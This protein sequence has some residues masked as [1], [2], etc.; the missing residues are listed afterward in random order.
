MRRAGQTTTTLVGRRY[1]PSSTQSPRGWGRARDREGNSSPEKPH[2]R[3]EGGR[4]YTSKVDAAD[5]WLRWDVAEDANAN[6]Y[7][8]TYDQQ[9][10]LGDVV[11]CAAT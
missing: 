6:G 8:G 9:R 1:V 11:C 4:R 5:S 7:E 10:R 3:K 2:S